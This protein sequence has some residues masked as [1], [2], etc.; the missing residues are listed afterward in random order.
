MARLD[1]SEQQGVNLV[2]R[3]VPV[4]QHRSVRRAR[5]D[6]LHPEV[7]EGQDARE[8]VQ[9]VEIQVDHRDPRGRGQT[10]LSPTWAGPVGDGFTEEP[11]SGYTIPMSPAALASVAAA[12]G[13]NTAPGDTE[14]R[15]RVYGVNA[16]LMPGR[17]A[18]TMEVMPR[19]A[20][21][22]DHTVDALTWYRQQESMAAAR[23]RMH[24]ARSEAG[25][26]R[27]TVPRPRLVPQMSTPGPA[28]GADHDED[29]EPTL[30]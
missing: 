29:V 3:T 25:R 8:W 17:E 11:E 27:R 23:D 7:P 14:G 10:T 19:S 26:Q 21:R 12:A 24:P 18:G 9:H 5:V 4:F 30:G 6:Q 28:S 16:D 22:S 13:E 20:R 15:T 2:L 1:K